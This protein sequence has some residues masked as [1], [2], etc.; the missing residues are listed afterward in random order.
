MIIVIDGYNVLKQ[1]VTAHACSDRQRAV[2]LS[3]LGVYVVRKNHTVVVVFDGGPHE[4]PSREHK[5]GVQV[6]YSGARHS[7]DDYI[8][9]YIRENKHKEILLVSSDGMLNSV[10]NEAGVPSIDSHSFYALLMQ[11]LYERKSDLT[12][13]SAGKQIDNQLVKLHHDIPSEVDK[14]MEEATRT[15]AHKEQDEPVADVELVRNKLARKDRR[16]LQILKKL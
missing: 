8:C 3:Q 14:Y 7:A 1:S 12:R 10:A 2:F 4:W 9:D 15:V 5:A 6:V 16:L 11:A 13:K